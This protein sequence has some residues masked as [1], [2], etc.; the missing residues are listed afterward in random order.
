MG[1]RRVRRAGSRWRL[2]V[3]EW[4]GRLQGY[5]TAHHWQSWPVDEVTRP[6]G[7]TDEDYARFRELV[8]ARRRAALADGSMVY[9]AVEG[10]EFDE[11]VAGRWLHVEQMDS[12]FWWMNIG[13]VTVHVRADRDGRPKRVTVSGPGD[14]DDP[15]PG[16]EYELDWSAP[17]DPPGGAG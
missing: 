14:Y 2:L 12:G 8:L 6:L 17:D 1:S 10:T 7:D 3:H 16:C 11:L 9:H 4:R 5:G 13:G 15:V